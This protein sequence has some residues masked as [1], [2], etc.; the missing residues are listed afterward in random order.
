MDLLGWWDTWRVWRWRLVVVC[1]FS[2]RTVWNLKWVK[3]K[4]TTNIPKHFL[5]LMCDYL[6]SGPSL[7]VDPCFHPL[8]LDAPDISWN[9]VLTWELSASSNPQFWCKR[10]ENLKSLRKIAQGQLQIT[11]SAKKNSQISWSQRA[12]LHQNLLTVTIWFPK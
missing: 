12:R 11:M 8:H 6:L 9:W 5:R 1:F 2:N 7:D 3:V 10:I 4:K